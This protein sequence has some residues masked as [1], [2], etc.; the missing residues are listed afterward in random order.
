MRALQ[1]LVFSLL[2]LSGVA[3]AAPKPNFD[4]AAQ[5]R[6][7]KSLPKL[8]ADLQA[9]I[10][11]GSQVQWDRSRGTASF[12][13]ASK[14]ASSGSTSLAR[15][16][17]APEQ[18]A[19]NYVADF[20]PLWGIDAD[21]AA[22]APLHS[23]HALGKGQLVRFG[24]QVNGVEVFRSELNVLMG[25]D[26]QLIALSGG[27]S[28]AK[29]TG[30]FRLSATEALARAFEDLDGEALDV[31][32]LA[33]ARVING[34]SHF[35][36]ARVPKNSVSFASEP[37]AKQ[38]YFELGDRLVPAYYVELNTGAKDA[39]D[40]D[41][42]A[43]V[44]S[45]D[46]GALLFRKDLTEYDAYTYRVW[47]DSTALN[48]P[49]DGPA[50]NDGTPNPFGIPNGFQMPFLAPS[51]ITI[52][53]SPFSQ[54]DPW[55]AAGATETS[56]NNADAYVDL[57]S[58]DGYGPI[59][60]PADP[61]TGDFRAQATGP[62]AFQHTYDT[63][64][65]PTSAEQRQAAI[66]QL[67][68]D[69][70]FLHDWYYDFGFDEQAGNAQLSNFGRGG[71]EGDPIKAEGQDFSGRN[72]ANMSTPADGG[73][74]RMQMYVFDPNVQVFTTVN[75]PANIAGNKPVGTAAFGPQFFD[76]TG[77]VVYAQPNTACS[78]LTNAAAVAGKIALIDRGTC[79]FT[80]KVKNAQNAG[81]IGVLAANNT[82]G[83]INMGGTD[84]TITI[85]A[86][87]I[88]QSDGNAIKTELTNGN[89]VNVRLYR[90]HGIDRD[91]TID[92]MVIA[93]EWAHYL[94]N[95]LI[96]NGSGLT[97]NQSRGMGEGWSDFNALLMTTKESD[98]LVPANANWSGTFAMSTYV[99]SGGGNNGYYFGIRRVPYS[100]DFSKNPLTFQDIQN[101]V[102][103]PA[104]AA[105][106]FGQNGANNAEVHNT[107]EVWASML[108]ECYV[109]LLR[110]S[111]RLTF[112]EAQDR[113]KR[114][115]VASLK[116]TPVTPT[117]T[118]AR[119][120]L[121]AAA[122]A[123]DPAD[124]DLFGQA[125]ARR[126][127]GTGAVSPD[128][129]SS[130]NV[131]V[132]ESYL[133]GNDLELVSATISDDDT[134]CDHDGYLD[135][136]ET[137]TVTVTIRNTGAETL[138]HASMSIQ[139]NDPALTFDDAGVVFPPVAPFGT[140]I[141]KVKVHYFGTDTA[142]FEPFFIS[143]SD[144]TLAQPRTLQA[145]AFAYV[146]ADVAS[147]SSTADGFDTSSLVWTTG[148][149]ANLNGSYPFQQQFTQLGG[150]VYAPDPS[151]GEDQ[152]FISPPL[153]VNATANLTL[154]FQHRFHFESDSGGAYDGAH[155]ELSNDNGAT[156]VDVG[157]PAYNGTLVTY[158]G[159]VNPIAGQPA[160]VGNNAGWPNFDTVNL[161]LGTTYAG[162][163]VQIRFRLASDGGGGDYGWELDDVQL[164]GI[165][166]T[167]FPSFVPNAGVCVN[168]HPLAS[169]SAPAQVDEN[170]GVTL[171]GSGSSDPDGDGLTYAWVQ[172][173]GPAVTLTGANTAS[174]T[175]TA[176]E[177][178]ADTQLAF[179]LTV[180][181]GTYSSSASV[182]LT[183]RNVNKVPVAAIAAAGP[184]AERTVV[185]LDGSGSSDADGNLASY[186]WTQTAGPSVALSGANTAHPTFVAPEV[187]ADTT[188]SFQLV[189]N[190]GQADSAPATIDVTIQN[191]NRAPVASSVSTL[192]VNE[193][194]AVTLD[195]SASSDLDGDALG[196]QWSQTA[197]PAVTLTGSTSA[198]A[199]FTAPQVD[200]DTEITFR[201]TVSDGIAQST[202]DVAVLVHNV[203]HLPNVVVIPSV[204]AS[205]NAQVQLDASGSTSP[206]GLILGFTWVQTSGPAVLLANPLSATPGFTAP[207]VIADTHLTFTVYVT[208][209]PS[210]SSANVDVLVHPVDHAPGAIATA[211]ISAGEGE[212]VTLSASGTDPDGD[213][214]GYTWTQLSGPT[215]SVSNASTA[216]ASFVAPAVSAATQ[217]TFDVAVSDGTLVAHQQVQ[218][219]VHSINHAPIARAG[220]ALTVDEG[221]NVQ[222]DGRASNDPDGTALSYSWAQLS[223]PTVALGGADSAQPTFVAPAVSTATTL[224]FRVTVTDGQ[225]ASTADVTITV[226]H[227]NRAPVVA[228]NA[229]TI[230]GSGS[231][232]T[233]D[234]SKSTDPEGAALTYHWVQTVGPTVTLTKADT[235]TATFTAPKVK[236][237]SALT[238]TLT[239]TDPAGLSSTKS[240]QVLVT[241]VDPLEEATSSGCSASPNAAGP[242]AWLAPLALLAF[243]FR[244]RRA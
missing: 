211:A 7:S 76:L 205:G 88:L 191:V 43:Y 139:A 52:A 82:T 87:S 193:G 175:F 116:L 196:Y 186:A 63:A 26:Q 18:A 224:T 55:L 67:F 206:D 9:R 179:T 39:T 65:P 12:V 229:P 35:G 194:D 227:V 69:V 41:Y 240:V 42:V 210:M 200:Q 83:I 47:A 74:P 157:G 195:G 166:N 115:L 106:A 70:N 228:I 66:Q 238:F 131:G 243:A 24:Q 163:T 50:G 152:Y 68:Y 244:R 184:F 181:D 237:S 151:A 140:A 173:G 11:P 147:N 171:D 130:T 80:V 180:T 95:R 197:G 207:D 30:A 162:Q 234:G 62:G 153:N 188:L 138:T 159:D 176:P 21:T 164:G 212:T 214:L 146:N 126:G 125:F 144:P 29:A 127:I 236:I 187:T 20:A 93:H 183:V 23:T 161:D 143:V 75:S 213:A 117:F 134:W 216:Q 242:F 61:A 124:F 25:A 220:S 201:L 100:V 99:T 113:M 235:A 15:W 48:V 155:V 27:F 132:V 203:V 114:Y 19:R 198:S 44:I 2:T 85:P 120:A 102:A 6:R 168:R 105:Y 91:G 231:T 118:E 60:A 199:S 208:D 77:D 79:T 136:G 53:N 32:A 90:E 3:L 45:A 121:L 22:N 204:A 5:V 189:V 185:A 46:D 172:T 13:W 1:S 233:L 38:T 221:A 223:G 4:A 31:S 56:G 110:D 37:R 98:A 123:Y 78:A 111:G 72:N 8:T 215:V 156:W 108:W 142:A 165:D 28:G 89:T 192:V 158:S 141:A 217:L 202:T 239:V 137:G 119:D 174:A 230:V 81:A 92:N 145:V 40:S 10:K 16:S 170:T 135:V 241:K 86:L 133:W 96:G 94:S 112:Q 226:Q 232:A 160:F 219:T 177:V 104:G 149:A 49:L 54:N 84:S 150:T 190:D 122:Y 128:R 209:G 107:G 36:F 218:V 59:A 51:D 178:L 57:V 34:Y 225:L 14:A 129:F 33:P 73:R 103:L 58:P 169:A 182:Q 222:L 154:S 17:S 64:Q 71:V 97:T 167:P 101:G 148:H 109:A